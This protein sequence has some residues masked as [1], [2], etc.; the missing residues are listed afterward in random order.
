MVAVPA[1]VPVLLDAS[2]VIA[3]LEELNAKVAKLIE[4]GVELPLDLLDG[5]TEFAHLETGATAGAG[6]TVLLKP[7]D[8][9]LDL[10]RTVRAI[11]G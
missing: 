9:L 5:L 4:N 2:E 11:D 6:V 8:A 10:L 1:A 7:S 3:I